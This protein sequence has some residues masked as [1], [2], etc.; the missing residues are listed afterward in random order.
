M[1][2]KTRRNGNVPDDFLYAVVYRQTDGLDALAELSVVLS[3]SVRNVT[4]KFEILS[5]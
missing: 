3:A 5:L 4:D 2:H 1:S